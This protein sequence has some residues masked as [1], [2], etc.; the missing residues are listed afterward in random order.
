MSVVVRVWTVLIIESPPRY[1]SNNIPRSKESGPCNSAEAGRA[2]VIYE[3]RTSCTRLLQIALF[4]ILCGLCNECPSS[5]R[6]A[7]T[8][9]GNSVS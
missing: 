7:T 9:F 1:T 4:S 2:G 8:H 3:Y 5:S 6:Q